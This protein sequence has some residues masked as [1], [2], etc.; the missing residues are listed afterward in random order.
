MNKNGGNK[1]KGIKVKIIKKHT[2]TQK[3][4]KYIRREKK[5]NENVNEKIENIFQKKMQ[6][7]KK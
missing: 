6:R 5:E 1:P 4:I 2:H 3:H 7:K